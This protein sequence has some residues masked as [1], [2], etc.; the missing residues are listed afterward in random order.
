VGIGVSWLVEL[1]GIVILLLY[2]GILGSISLSLS[3]FIYLFCR[4][5]AL[6]HQLFLMD[7]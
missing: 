6:H 2:I 1:L 7:V 3:V 4:N 5:V